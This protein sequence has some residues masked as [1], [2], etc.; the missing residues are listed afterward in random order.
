MTDPQLQKK[1][2]KSKVGKKLLRFL[3]GDANR[4]KLKRNRKDRARIRMIRQVSRDQES[5]LDDILRNVL[6][7]I[8]PITQPLVLNTQI[9]HSGGSLLNRLLDGHP[10]LNAL[11]HEIG[12]GT[13]ATGHWPGIDLDH[14]PQ[15]WFKTLYKEVDIKKVRK[16]FSCDDSESTTIPFVF[17]PLIQ[18]QIFLRYLESTETMRHRDIIEAYITSCFG[19]WLDYQNLSGEKKFT[20]IYAPDLATQPE[21]MESFFGIYPESKII[22]LIRKPEDWFACAQRLEPEVYGDV[23]QSIRC[24]QKS[25][26]A[27]REI[28]MKF[29]D[30][31]CLIRFEDLMGRTEAVMRFVSEFLEI[32]FEDILLTPTFNSIPFQPAKSPKADITDAP[33]GSFIGARELDEEQ[34]KMIQEMTK[35]DYQTILEAVAAV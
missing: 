9:H 7:H 22:S 19:A 34:R 5:H 12:S 26:K 8:M 17:L 10:E 32:S 16:K 13:P 6:K 11:P 33:F 3:I 14:K 24:W 27:V 28:N 31:V 29:G 2:K 30:R 15:G 21:S 4:R 1:A 23:N 18:E 25:V 35:E 20:T